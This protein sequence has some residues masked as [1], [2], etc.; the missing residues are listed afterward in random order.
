M[1]NSLKWLFAATALG[2]TAMTVQAS[3]QTEPGSEQPAQ[4]AALTEAE[5]LAIDAKHYAASYG[6]SFEEALER[7][8]IMQDSGEQIAAIAGK[9][10]DR[11]SGM[12]FDNRGDFSLVVRVTGDNAPPSERLSRRA[13][14]VQAGGAGAV[15][16]AVA[17]RLG[18][19]ASDVG[20]ARNA[21]GREISREVRY[22]ATAKATKAQRLARQNAARS[23]LLADANIESIADN[24]ETGNAIVYVKEDTSAVRAKITE[25]LGA[26]FEL[27][28]VP[29]GIVATHTRGGSKLR[30]RSTNELV[31]LTA[32]AVKKDYATTYGA[33]TAGHCLDP[34]E[35]AVPLK[36]ADKADG[37]VYDVTSHTNWRNDASYDLGWVSAEHHITN[38]FYAD[39][40]STPRSLTARANRLYD[41]RV[42]STTVKGSY[43]C[44]LGQTS[45]TDET[46]IQSCGEVTSVTGGNHKGGSTYVHVSNT[47]SGAGTVRTSGLG[48]LRCFRG[49]SGG[50][51]FATTTAYGIHSACGW[52]DSTETI[53]TVA[54]YTS[55]DLISNLAVTL[56]F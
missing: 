44:H 31:C 54:V 49:D 32:F 3:A 18:L 10:R 4:G 42:K 14:P 8:L 19:T 16:S 50:P 53:T 22:K 37:F 55:V 1:A 34:A 27:V 25:A 33:L 7:L 52:T 38:Q 11:L 39:S 36:Y 45:N 24:E 15:P 20:T 40:G 17:Q 56:V 12:F 6:V 29:T 5:A 26:E 9:H 30:D 41:T 51:W 28:V 2:A 35:G 43:I 46:L 13:E 48:T 23:A 21:L 47:Q